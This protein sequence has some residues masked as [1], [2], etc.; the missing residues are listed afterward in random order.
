[1][2]QDG[3][4]NL[5]GDESDPLI[6]AEYRATATERTP[7]TLDAAVL[8]TAEAAAGDSGLRGFTAFWFRPLAFV[9]TLGLSLALLL[10]LNHSL[11]PQPIISP[12]SEVG[13]S[14]VQSVVADPAPAFL[15]A[16][17]EIQRSADAPTNKASVTQSK[18]PV[19]ETGR[20]KRQE[21]T[22]SS[23]YD[24]VG[25]VDTSADF[26][27]MIEA[28]SKQIQ[29]QHGVAEIA[30]EGLKQTRSDKPEQSREVAAFQASAL[31]LVD[32]ARPCTE[33]QLAVPEMWWQCISDLEEDG[34]YSEANAELDL[35]NQ[36]NPDFEATEIYPSQ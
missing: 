29:E 23:A 7:P 16:T 10:E 25:N 22:A 28:S 21:S 35:F 34:R 30:I 20:L 19:V 14:E 1:M 13:R 4:N 11:Q 18:D 6:S 27:E 15:G 24:P 36:A 8:K 12:A 9:A 5:R 31:L 32:P 2:N 33:E 26:A 3:E 17:S